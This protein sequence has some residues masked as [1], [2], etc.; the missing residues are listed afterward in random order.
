MCGDLTLHNPGVRNFRHTPQQ[1]VLSPFSYLEAELARLP[2]GLI[3]FVFLAVFAPRG[4]VFRVR[5]FYSFLTI[6]CCAPLLL[7]VSASAQ[8]PQSN[9]DSGNPIQTETWMGAQI[10][11]RSRSIYSGTTMAPFGSVQKDGWRIRVVG[12]YGQYRY[13]GARIVSNA[14][15][16]VD[17]DGRHGF[18][19][20]LI[21]YQ[22]RRGPL[23]LKGFIGAA[24]VGHVISP[25]DPD[26]PMTGTHYGV[27]GA[28]E[29]WYNLS[30]SVW[31]SAN[32]GASSVFETA[33]ADLRLGY[34]LTPT[35]DLG[36]EGAATHDSHYGTQRIGA[37]A[38]YRWGRV[39]LRASGG[40]SQDSEDKHGLYGA[41]NLLFAY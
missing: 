2:N 13:E 12:G 27:A 4:L 36:I 41:I 30:D 20:F 23:T 7:S 34:R 9:R 17:Y 29:A 11:A 24:A 35:F 18:G 8:T 15:L 25:L 6:W 26:S 39:E 37:F 14:Q 33:R 38:Q 32:L 3:D 19:E 21:G 16:A 40:L 22:W 10:A 1:D 31:L 28:L 5:F